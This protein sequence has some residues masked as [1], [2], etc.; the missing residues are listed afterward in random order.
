MPCSRS[1]ALIAIL[2]AVLPAAAAAGP[3]QDNSFL[4]EEAYNQEPGVIQH[5][6]A[7]SRSRE[8]GAW[9]YSFTE[10]W[11]IRGQT[12][13]GSVTF[14]YADLKA[15]NGSGSAT[16]SSTTGGRPWGAVRRPSRS[17]RASRRSCPRE[18]PIGGSEAEVPESR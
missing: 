10:E 7:F 2:S 3:I 13:Q 12:H 5:I 1:V 8:D 11:P 15:V 9:V 16:C 6:S 4:L 17:P 14:N 18:T